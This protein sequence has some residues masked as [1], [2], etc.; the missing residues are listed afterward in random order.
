M[1]RNLCDTI[2]KGGPYA[3]RRGKASPL[4]CIVPYTI[5]NVFDTDRESVTSTIRILRDTAIYSVTYWIRTVRDTVT[6][7]IPKHLCCSNLFDTVPLVLPLP[8]GYPI[9]KVLTGG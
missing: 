8:F 3:N 6:I 2:T 7:K 9:K 4:L 5:R 1:I